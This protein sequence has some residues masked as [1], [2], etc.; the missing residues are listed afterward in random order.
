MLF[1]GSLFAPENND[2]S[3]QF[4]QNNINLKKN[5]WK[6][7]YIRYGIFFCLRN[8]SEIYD[9]R[10]RGG[11][12]FPSLSKAINSRKSVWK[13]SHLWDFLPIR[14]GRGSHLINRRANRNAAEIYDT[15]SIDKYGINIGESIFCQYEIIVQLFFNASLRFK[16]AVHSSGGLVVC[17]SLPEII[18]SHRFENRK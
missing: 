12:S 18:F 17:L 7:F 3:I 9:N 5:S 13:F 11:L 10:F 14:Y 16:P 4:Q 1:S 15:N 2:W 8:K 6:I